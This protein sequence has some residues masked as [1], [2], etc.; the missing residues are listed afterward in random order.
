MDFVPENI[1]GALVLNATHVC[2]V[3]NDC[4]S[5]AELSVG[6]HN[7][8]VNNKLRYLLVDFQ[9]EKEVCN[10]ILSELLQ[11]KKRL[12][13]PFIFCGMMDGPK[14]YLKSFAYDEHPC[15]SSPDEAIVY[16]KQHVPDV[17]LVDLK[18][19]KTGEPI[20]CTRS[21]SYRAEEAGAADLDDPEGEPEI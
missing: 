13:M 21:R 7:W 5:C 20:P 4:R 16:L 9:D 14:K 8:I 3:G 19:V 18:Q 6:V 17:L 15:F 1:N 2:T 12:R 10:A 11:L